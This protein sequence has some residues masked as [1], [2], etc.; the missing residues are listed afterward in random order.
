ML[1]PYFIQENNTY[2]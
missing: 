1:V 2:F